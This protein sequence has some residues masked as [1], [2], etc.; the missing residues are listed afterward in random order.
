MVAVGVGGARVVAGGLGKGKGVNAV[1][2]LAVLEAKAVKGLAV[3]WVGLGVGLKEAGAAVVVTPP[4]GA[5][6]LEILTSP[7][8]TACLSS[9][10]KVPEFESNT[11][12][13][14]KLGEA[15]PSWLLGCSA[16]SSKVMDGRPR[17]KLST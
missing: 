14:L 9:V 2:V 11:R 8:G 17:V 6:G 15:A 7:P 1:G 5:A 3:G 4:A 16:S 10:L 12:S 13:V